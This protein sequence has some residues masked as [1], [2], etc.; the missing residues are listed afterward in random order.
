MRVL[1]LFSGIGG[2]AWALE[3]V[4]TVVAALDQD[5]AARETYGRRFDH[6]T[7]P[8]NL[9]HVKPEWFATFEADLWWM[10]PPCQPY[11]IRGNQ[12]DLEDRRSQAFLRVCD[13]IETHRPAHVGLENVPWFADSQGEAR[14]VGLLQAQ[15]Y[16]VHRGLLCPTRLGVPAQRRRY[17][18]VASRDGLQDPGPLCPPAHVLGDLV[19]EDAD[20]ALDVE[21]EL[22]R[23]YEGALHTVDADDPMALAVCFTGAYGRSPVHAGS[24]LRQ[25]GRVRRFSP[26][27][28]GRTLGLGDVPWPEDLPRRKRW[29]LVGNSL[30]VHAVRQVLARIPALADG[31]R[32]SAE[33]P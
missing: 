24:Y 14:L 12:R 25:H 6:P 18:L 2:V 26:T 15:G 5:A 21:P 23:K 10:S 4:A 8:R 17:Y 3:G 29:K 13:A 33:A 31:L 19:D 27:E 1:E 22:A 30:S 7:F 20:P 32:K 16:D 28:I 9:H 11:T